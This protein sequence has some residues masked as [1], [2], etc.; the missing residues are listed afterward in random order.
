MAPEPVAQPIRARAS[1]HDKQDIAG[2]ESGQAREE[3]IQALGRGQ[4]G[5][6]EVV[7]VRA[8]S[9]TRLLPPRGAAEPVCT[10]E[11][12]GQMLVSGNRHAIPPPSPILPVTKQDTG[13]VLTG[14]PV[15]RIREEA[16]GSSGCSVSWEQGSETS[17]SSTL[18][19]TTLHCACP[20]LQSILLWSYTPV[21]SLPSLGLHLIKPLTKEPELGITFANF[22]KLHSVPWFSLL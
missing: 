21:C 15:L 4:Q 13:L 18:V 3:K 6:G 9:M 22:D 2:T 11:S 16:E 8:T 7:L 17:F 19:G 12:S 20:C 1:S 14:A 10:Q 5:A